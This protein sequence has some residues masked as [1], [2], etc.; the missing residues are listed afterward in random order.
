MRNY[1]ARH[2]KDVPTLVQ[3][4][5]EGGEQ[6]QMCSMKFRCSQ[7]VMTIRERGKFTL[8]DVR[9]IDIE[10]QID[11]ERSLDEK[12]YM[13]YETSSANPPSS[14]YASSTSS[15]PQLQYRYDVDTALLHKAEPNMTTVPYLADQSIQGERCSS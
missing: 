7:Q 10:K 15:T 2:S 12:N 14:M 6:A 5:G 3:I 4:V 9:H 11:T 13:E 8:A 1:Q